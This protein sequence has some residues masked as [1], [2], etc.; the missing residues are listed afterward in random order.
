MVWSCY[1][2]TLLHSQEMLQLL[3]ISYFFI[4]IFIFIQLHYPGRHKLFFLRFYLFIFR[5]RGKEGE[6]EGEQHRCVRETSKSEILIHC[7]LNSPHQWPATQASALTG[8]PSGNLWFAGWCPTHWATPARAISYYLIYHQF[9]NGHFK[10]CGQLSCVEKLQF[11]STILKSLWR[12]KWPGFPYF[13]CCDHSRC[14]NTLSLWWLS[15]HKN[16]K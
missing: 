13:S 1:K 12:V 6:R 7:L 10:F 3:F 2:R 11:M 14:I 8:N 5:E 4:F 15:I 16:I 9:L